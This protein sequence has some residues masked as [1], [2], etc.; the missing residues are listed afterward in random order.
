[1]MPE[2]DE[3][4]GMGF[5]LRLME[6]A[7]KS[8]RL[9]YRQPKKTR[10]ASADLLVSD[11]RRM[12]NPIAI[13]QYPDETHVILY[14]HIDADDVAASEPVDEDFSRLAIV[15][16]KSGDRYMLRS[17]EH[18]DGKHVH[19]DRKE[20]KAG[21]VLRLCLVFPPLDKSVR[22]LYIDDGGKSL[23]TT[24]V[25]NLSDIRRESAKVIN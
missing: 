13:E 15:D 7:V 6:P 21:T 22:Q 16:A 8:A 24:A 4:L 25:Y 1:M 12:K 17:V 5:H 9:S 20:L 19:I 3:R 23:G 14:Y 11:V 18:F 2:H 10:L